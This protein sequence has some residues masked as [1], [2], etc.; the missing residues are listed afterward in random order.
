MKTTDPPDQISQQFN[1]APVN[2]LEVCSYC[3][4]VVC[5]LSLR[6]FEIYTVDAELSGGENARIRKTEGTGK[7]PAIL[8]LY[9]PEIFK[10]KQKERAQC[11]DRFKLC[12]PQ[13]LF[14][15]FIPRF[16][17][18]VALNVNISLSQNVGL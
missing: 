7:L 13:P 18:G 11:V 15:L 1:M 14:Q 8:A 5:F 10:E 16:A 17:H 3:S 6:Y 9:C 12:A 2:F 4:K